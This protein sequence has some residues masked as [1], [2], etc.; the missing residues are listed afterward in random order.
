M[1]WAQHAG[2]VYLRFVEMQYAF[3]R[4]LSCRS[5]LTTPIRIGE[6]AHAWWGFARWRQVRAFH[7]STPS[8][9][10][11]PSQKIGESSS[12]RSLELPADPLDRRSGANSPR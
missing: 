11:G 12:R 4:I 9:G 6:T 5:F 8:Y 10:G 3:V 2:S 7:H 1:G